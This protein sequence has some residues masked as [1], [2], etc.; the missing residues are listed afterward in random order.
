MAKT[1]ALN[2]SEGKLIACINRYKCLL[3]LFRLLNCYPHLPPNT[4]FSPLLSSA[5]TLPYLIYCFA[6]LST[7]L[8]LSLSLSG[9][10]EESVI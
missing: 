8:H 6:A 2:I 7:S 1:E 5:T 4:S 3:A 9:Q 10:W